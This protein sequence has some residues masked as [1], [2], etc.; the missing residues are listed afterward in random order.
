MESLYRKFQSLRYCIMLTKRKP[1]LVWKLIKLEI[2][3]LMGIYPLFRTVEIATTYNCNL[4]CLHCSA[5]TLRES[6]KENLSLDDYKRIGDECKKYDVPLVTF[7]GG[8]PLLDSR[9]EEIISYFSPESTIIGITT[10]GT[11]LNEDKI[12]RLKKLGADT[13][14][15]SIDS[16]DPNVHDSFR[17]IKGSFDKTFNNIKLTR[18]EDI[19][20]ENINRDFI[21]MIDFAKELG[22]KLH[23][24]LAAPSGKWANEKSC[25]KYLLTEDDRE[26]LSKLRSKYKFIRRDIDGNYGKIGC[27]AGTE[28]LCITPTGDVMPC[29]KIHVSFGNVKE[30]SLFDI[31]KRVLSHKEFS[32]TPNLCIAAEDRNFIKK[33]MTKSFN[34]DKTLLSEHEFFGM[35]K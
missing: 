35:E 8:E 32:E 21:K 22:L 30:D 7:T 13:F 24:S 3:M 28:R 27:P 19:D 25:D 1:R 20:D 5:D 11:L 31:R 4:K 26:L 2:K 23:T 6:D 17:N 33:Y 14:V 34:K 29:T 18:K 16:S 10:N 9:L 15:I 12:K